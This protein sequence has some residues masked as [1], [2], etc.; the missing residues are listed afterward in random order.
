MRSAERNGTLAPLLAALA[1]NTQLA[2][3][4]PSLL[5]LGLAGPELAS[6]DPSAA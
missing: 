3:R 2:P 5:S 1:A 6:P 4:G